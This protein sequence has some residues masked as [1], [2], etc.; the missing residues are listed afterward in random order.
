MLLVT[1]GGCSGM[2]GKAAGRDTADKRQN[3]ESAVTMMRSGLE[4]EARFFLERVI[5]DT[6]EEGVT[7]EALFRLALLK[8]NDGQLGGGRSSLDL[9]AKLRNK[10]P[11]SVWTKQVLPLYT[12]LMGE[13]SARNR[14]RELISMREKNLSLSRDVREL[15]QTIERLKSLDIELEQKIRR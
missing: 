6:W 2:F 9:I 15:R 13:K 5:D 1:L 4:S 7:D 14:E 10:Y 8:I 11:S 3:L 12:N